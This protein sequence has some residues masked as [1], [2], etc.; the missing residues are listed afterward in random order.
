MLTIE[1]FRTIHRSDTN[2]IIHEA[3]ALK[4]LL[5]FRGEE[6]M[7]IEAEETLYVSYDHHSYLSAHWVS[8]D[9]QEHWVG[10]IND[11]DVTI[12]EHNNG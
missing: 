9:G 5:V 6:V 7:T 2:L 4:D 11:S 1:M 12:K 3:I 10:L 8:L